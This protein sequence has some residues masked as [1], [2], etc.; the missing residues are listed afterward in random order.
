M[1]TTCMCDA[2]DDSG[3]LGER[4]ARLLSVR[5]KSWDEIPNKLKDPRAPARA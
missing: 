5:G 4:A 3:S 2:D 1:L